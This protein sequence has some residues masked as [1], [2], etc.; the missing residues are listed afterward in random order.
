MEKDYLV[1]G[2]ICFGYVCQPRQRP[3]MEACF[4]DYVR[5]IVMGYWAVEVVTIS[6]EQRWHL[7]HAQEE[8]ENLVLCAPVTERPRVLLAEPPKVGYCLLR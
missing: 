8:N 1:K 6:S 5:G 7:Y 4:R 3:W 2:Q